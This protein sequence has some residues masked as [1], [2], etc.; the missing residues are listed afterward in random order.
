MARAIE[1]KPRRRSPVRQGVWVN[2]RQWGHAEEAGPR[3]D[4]WNALTDPVARRKAAARDFASLME[5]VEG[6]LEVWITDA[7]N[8][9]DVAVALSDRAIE[10]TLRESFIDVVCQ[11]LDA[12]EG[13]LFVFD[14]EVAD[15]AKQGQRLA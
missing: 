8:D 2:R 3:P 13:S 9:L 7:V 5:D 10:A 1:L 6:L 4:L 14:G 11:R 15:W 12:S